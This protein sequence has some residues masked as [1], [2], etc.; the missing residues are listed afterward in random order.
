MVK[1][2]LSK[3]LIREPKIYATTKGPIAWDPNIT[4]GLSND[5]FRN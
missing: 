1:N 4:Y 2:N 5:L 3:S